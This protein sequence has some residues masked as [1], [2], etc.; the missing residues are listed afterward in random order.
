MNCA[1]RQVLTAVVPLVV[2]VGVGAVSCG[3]G[4][5]P[6]VSPTPPQR[7]AAPAAKR[8]PPADHVK[9]RKGVRH[10][11]GSKQ[12]VV[13]CGPCHGQDLRGGQGPSCFTCHGQEWH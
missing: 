11:S 7:A 3:C 12:A 5:P 4:A 8:N 9:D 10:K 6:T 13:N 2:V 1:F